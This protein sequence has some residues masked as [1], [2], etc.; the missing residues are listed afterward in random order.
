MTSPAQV[1]TTP[2]LSLVKPP[3]SRVGV[4]KLVSPKL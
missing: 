4:R 2:N 1:P 3:I